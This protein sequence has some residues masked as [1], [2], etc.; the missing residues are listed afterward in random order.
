MPL[1]S[2]TNTSNKGGKALFTSIFFQV[3]RIEDVPEAPRPGG[4]VR[5]GLCRES[6]PINSTPRGEYRGAENGKYFC[7]IIC[8][9]FR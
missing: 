7:L 8:P 6:A 4:P 2:V 3:S 5:V 9:F 1:A